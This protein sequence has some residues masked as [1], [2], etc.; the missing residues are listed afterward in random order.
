MTLDD[1]GFKEIIQ[2][3]YAI[4]QERYQLYILLNDKWKLFRDSLAD[5]SSAYEA[6]LLDKDKLPTAQF[7]IGIVEKETTERFYEIIPHD[8]SR[9]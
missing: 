5:F 1:Y 9:K 7:L 3:N 4:I 2:D 6:M 8:H